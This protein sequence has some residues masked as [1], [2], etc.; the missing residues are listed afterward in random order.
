MYTTSIMALLVHLFCFSAI[1]EPQ[2]SP[3]KQPEI[4][5]ESLRRST[6]ASDAPDAS[7]LRFFYGAGE[8]AFAAY[9]VILEDPQSDPRLVV[10]I[11]ALLTQSKS[12]RS[13]FLPVI[14]KRLTDPEVEVRYWALFVVGLIGSGEDLTPIVAFLSSDHERTAKMAASAVARIG[15]EAGLLALDIWLLTTRE[16]GDSDVRQHVRSCRDTLRKKLLETTK[17]SR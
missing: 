2:D 5:P 13:R 7:E 3:K 15:G 14:R 9:L 8:R 12:D 17:T 1:N 11:C 4:S 16:R 6:L 10:Q